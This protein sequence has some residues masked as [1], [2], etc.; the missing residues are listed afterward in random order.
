MSLGIRFADKRNITPNKINIVSFIFLKT[1]FY[2][3]YHATMRYFIIMF[4]R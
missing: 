2:H 1:P 4:D 3:A